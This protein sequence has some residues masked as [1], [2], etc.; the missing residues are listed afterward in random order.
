MAL[1]GVVLFGLR[2]FGA[3]EALDKERTR[4]VE[5]RAAGRLLAEKAALVDDPDYG[6]V[7][8][9]RDLSE[10]LPPD[11][12]KL[13]PAQLYGDLFLP[14]LPIL[15]KHVVLDQEPGV[16]E[17]VGVS[18]PERP[19]RLVVPE[20]GTDLLTSLPPRPLP[21]AL[22]PALVLGDG[23]PVAD[24]IGLDGPIA[25][26]QFTKETAATGGDEVQ[27][28]QPLAGVDG[29]T[30]EPLDVDL[31]DKAE[32]IPIGGALPA[33]AGVMAGGSLGAGSVEVDGSIRR[34]D[35]LDLPLLQSDEWRESLTSVILN[36]ETVT[37]GAF[38]IQGPN[39]E[40]ALRVVDLRDWRVVLDE[41]RILTF[42]GEPFYRVDD[43]AGVR[44]SFD[45]RTLTLEITLPA[46]GF[47]RTAVETARRSTLPPQSGVGAFLDYDALYLTGD[48]V[49][50]RL[51]AL[52]EVGAF[53]EFGVLVSDFRAGDLTEDAEL[54]RLET[55]LTKDFPDQRASVRVGDSV[56][57]SGSLGRPVRFGGV[58]L[59]SNFSTDPNFVTF[60]LPTIGGL[61]EQNSV[62]EVFLN[63]TVRVSE[64]V[65]AGPFE[66]D[67]L[68]V[69]TG[70]GEVQL[71]VT[72]LLGREQFL[73]QSYYV[74]PR[75]LK[76]GLSD[77]SVELGFERERFNVANF[78]YGRPLLI[79]NESY[80]FSDALTGDVRGEISDDRQA[81]GLGGAALLGNYGLVSAGV[82]GSRDDDAGEGY[83][84]FADYEYRGRNF[85]I[86]L[87]TEYADEK[88]RQ[89]G[90]DFEPIKRTDQVALGVGL[91]QV[92][93]LGAILINTETRNDRDRR[94]VVTNY[95][96]PLGPGSLLLSGLGVIKPEE[97]YALT[98]SYSLP[99][100][101]IRSMT[102]TANVRDDA[103]GARVQYRRGRGGSDLG[104][105]YR[106]ATEIG[107]TPRRFDGTLRYDAPQATAQVDAV[108]AEDRVTARGNLSGSVGLIDGRPALSRRLGR[109]FGMVS[110][111]GHPDVMVYLEN[112][113][114]GRTDEDGYLLLPRLNPYQENRIR[115]KAEDL[116]LDTEIEA[117]ELV[118]VPYE[119]SGVQVAFN[120]KTNRS[121]LATLIAADG[122][123]LP[124]GME[125]VT[126]DGTLE[127]RVADQGLAYIKGE[128]TGGGD[129]VSK[130]GLPPFR[131]PL[132]LL[133]SEP[134][135]SLG[136]IQC[137]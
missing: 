102:A 55:S 41:D 116:P 132:P 66:I 101:P 90:Q 119:R 105:S 43:L 126:S 29:W 109:A 99:L 88:F 111:P 33:L 49:R 73:T 44:S 130:P 75:L 42:N 16:L 100:S 133:P 82:I 113:E 58:Q 37:E 47:D 69:V 64:E 17:F 56:T 89:I 59:A 135:A 48:G 35:P 97:D 71:R 19:A 63:N 10:K 95:S 53:N 62:A 93:R 83:E 60:P 50:E 84:A 121:A 136:D 18:Y 131:C 96:V 46:S 80:G 137:Q 122:S 129:L 81:F 2:A 27:V 125:M 34:R 26:Q 39:D 106:V 92:G 25:L 9:L 61:A 38:A 134:M 65:P 94:S 72:D 23:G 123:P 103:S 52:L 118:A 79:G 117:E 3:G 91:G 36:G 12:P 98:A 87:R 70:A 104:A 76:E 32:L 5:V 7:L 54:V 128:G 22:V 40:W 6:L 4:F 20:Q 24:L 127:A 13:V 110:L 28:S 107:D 15:V 124:A 8:R 31:G 114:V 77:Y 21:V 57:S 11:L 86:G 112:R 78:D 85:N 1:I 30:L 74:S 67:N 51:D 120:V 115:I 45:E 68:P 108:Y 14:I